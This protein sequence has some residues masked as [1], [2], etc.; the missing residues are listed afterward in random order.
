MSRGF[1]IVLE[2]IDVSGKSTVARYLA[3]ILSEKGYRTAITREPSDGPVGQ[4][5]RELLR[6]EEVKPSIVYALLFVADRYWH[7]ENVVRKLLKLGYIVI[8]E[9]GFLS[10]LAYQSAQGVPEDFLVE[11][12]R[13]LPL[14]DLIVIL[15]IDKET[16]A[17]R[18][19]T[20]TSPSV[21][22]RSLDFLMKVQ[23]YYILY[24]DKYNAV[25]IEN[26]DSYE[27]AQQIA[28]LVEEKLRS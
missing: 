17:Q 22:E 7:Y 8:Q 5:I 13:Y 9:R 10:T 23:D 6:Q 11:L 15:K 26:R 14:P 20:R 21:F 2:G 4:F 19:R 27:T 28:K 12:H 3:D 16:A 25:V 18:L 1:W 24:A